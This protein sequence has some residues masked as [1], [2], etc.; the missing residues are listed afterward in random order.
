M[1]SVKGGT[2]MGTSHDAGGHYN[3]I[4]NGTSCEKV[5]IVC[6]YYLFD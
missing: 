2:L 5:Y 4:D 6:D 3:I 1:I